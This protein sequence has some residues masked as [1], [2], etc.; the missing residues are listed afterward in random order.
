MPIDTGKVL[1]IHTGKVKEMPYG[2][3]SITTAYQ[4][5]KVEGSIF[6]SKNGFQGDE[7]YYKGHGGLD[8]AV[9]I[10][11]VD[12]YPYWEEKFGSIAEDSMFG[13]NL[14]VQGLTEEDVHVGDIYEFG[15]AVIQ[16]TEPRGPCHIIAKRYG[17]KTIPLIM[18]QTGWTGYYARVLKEGMV[19]SGNILKRKETHEDR[20]TILKVNELLYKNEKDESLLH[21]LIGVEPL[22]SSLREDLQRKAEKL[23][24]KNA[25]S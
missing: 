15:D 9:C 21:T 19:S 2:D 12:H 8:K 13:E 17:D 25:D 1:S 18:Q 7:H 14:T 4:K 5:G 11:S 20:I 24:K 6:L 22:S 23:K 16:I 10:Y 3:K